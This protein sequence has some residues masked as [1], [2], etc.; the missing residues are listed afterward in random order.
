MKTFVKWFIV[1]AWAIGVSVGGF[2]FANYTTREKVYSGTSVKFSTDTDHFLTIDS[3]EV[4]F[5]GA[6]SEFFLLR[7]V[8]GE[9]IVPASEAPPVGWTSDTYYHFGPTKIP[10]GK[11]YVGEGKPSV[12]ITSDTPINVH[13]VQTEDQKTGNDFFT[14]FIGLIVWVVGLLVLVLADFFSW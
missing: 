14:G 5:E 11:W 12:Q 10:G 9:T 13:V 8:S 1:I 2:Y 3:N 7:K 6:S 4:Q